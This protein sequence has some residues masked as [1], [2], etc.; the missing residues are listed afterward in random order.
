MKTDWLNK[1]QTRLRNEQHA[2]A[3]QGLLDDIKNEMRRRGIAPTCRP[4]RRRKVVAL[5]GI[6]A[7]SIAAFLTVGL[8]IVHRMTLPSADKPLV[9][10]TS[11]SLLVPPN[12]ASRQPTPHASPHAEHLIASRPGRHSVHKAHNLLMAHNE[13]PAQTGAQPTETTPSQPRSDTQTE[14]PSHRI[15]PAMPPQSGRETPPQRRPS[16]DDSRWSFA[17]SYDGLSGSSHTSQGVLLA[18]ANPYG[19]YVDAFSGHERQN[20]ANGSGSIQMKTKHHRPVKFGLSVGYNIHRRWHIQ[21]GLTYSRLVSDFTCDMD[22]AESAVEQELH[23]IGL[24]V[25]MGYSFY[26]TRRI[27]LYT[28]A[29]G[30]V[31]KLVK[32]RAKQKAAQDVVPPTSA[33]TI[34]EH[35]PIFSIH[36]AVGGEIR[37]NPALSAYVEPGISHHFNNGSNV[38]NVYKDKPTSL[39][40]NVGI[41]VYLNK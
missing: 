20:Y 8:Y 19:E 5:W 21:T 18:A 2:Q 35:A 15:L 24:P 37:F 27:N 1:V 34:T 14:Q 11:P 28:M 23:Y 38:K 40:L 26:K 31:E 30:E 17:T 36:A 13:L 16:T 9:S 33:E 12:I 4:P 25:S 29:G 41:R 3:P 22:N 6:R 32:G 10:A 39:S 7:A